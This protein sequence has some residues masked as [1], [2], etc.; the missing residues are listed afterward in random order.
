MPADENAVIHE[1]RNGFVE[2]INKRHKM[3]KH[4]R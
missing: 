2:E 3:I 1:Y 4:I